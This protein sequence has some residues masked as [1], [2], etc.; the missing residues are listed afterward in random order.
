[1]GYKRKGLLWLHN[2]LRLHDNLPLTF[3]CQQCDELTIVYADFTF[4]K[5]PRACYSNHPIGSNRLQFQQ[6]TLQD[7]SK[8][9]K[10]FNQRLIVLHQMSLYDWLNFI[11]VNRFTDIYSSASSDYDHVLRQKVTQQESSGIQFHEYNSFTIFDEQPMDILPNS[12]SPFRRTIEKNNHL[13]K[14]SELLGIIPTVKEMPPVPQDLSCPK[15][16][17]NS[18]PS[19]KTF[20]GGELSALNHLEKYFSTDLPASYKKTRNALDDWDSSTKFSAWLANGSLSVRA[21]INRLKTYEEQVTA[22]DSTYW[23]WFELLWREYFQWYAKCHAQKLFTFSGISKTKPLTSFYSERYNQWCHGT[24]RYPLVNAIMKQLTAT[25]YISNRARQ[26]AASCF[27]NELS[28]DWRYGAS[29]FERHLLDFDVANN[30]GNW[31]YIAGV[32]ADPRGGRH[33]NLNKQTEL[34]D[35][36][37]EYILRWNGH[38]N[39]VYTDSL[40]AA[41]WPVDFDSDQSFK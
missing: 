11:R 23:I 41:D 30:W 4:P 36:K 17:V 28:L 10:R 39:C 9:L 22:N 6:Q 29:F 24:T 2:D 14:E 12:F 31:Q 15:V 40:N 26:I 5:H 18:K 34:Y 19:S 21:L 7:L 37:E 32:G 25:G 35:P 16:E 1:M 27:V 3:A 20:S 13:L 38:S 33:F 8:S